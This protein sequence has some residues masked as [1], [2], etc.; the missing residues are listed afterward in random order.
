MA[1]RNIRFKVGFDLDNQ[2]ISQLKSEL[3]SLQQL[4]AKDIK[5]N[6]GEDA[7]EELRKIKESAAEI[8][9]ALNKAFNA[10]L[11]TLN[12]SK[13]NQE[14]K[15]VDTKQFAAGLERAGAAGVTSFNRLAGT[16]LSTNLQLKQTFSIVEKMRTTLSNTIKWQVASS[17]IN[18]MTSSVQQAFSY[19]KQLD[20]ALTDIRI[21]TG[22]SSDEMA[23]F[24]VQANRAAQ[25]LGKTTKDYAKA[26]LTYYQQGLGDDEVRARTE[27]TLKAANVT[28][29]A[30][31]EVAEDLTAVWN[32]YKITTEE[33]TL[34]VDKLAAVA[35]SSASD[36][37]ELATAMSKVASIANNMG[38]DIDQLN[39]QISTIIATTR[40][41]PET[42][43]NALK[44]IYA[45]INDIV[46]GTDEAETSLG[47]YSG[48][49]ASLGIS[50]LDSNGK[51]RDTGEVMEEIG[52]KWG[53]M[54]REQQVYLAKTMAGQR[55]MNNLIALF[56]N[57]S[58]YQ[59][60]INVSMSSVGALDEKNARY[61]ESVAAHAKTFSAAVEG[62]Q[63]ELVD[64]D[65]MKSLYDLGTDF[66][67]LITKIVDGIGGGKNA[68]LLMT[69][70]LT[71]LFQQKITGGLATIMGNSGRKEFNRQQRENQ[72]IASQRL[73]EIAEATENP[74]I[75]ANTKELTKLKDMAS[76]YGDV[77]TEENE[78]VLNG[79]IKNK[80]ELIETNTV[81]KEQL[82]LMQDIAKAQNIPYEGVENLFNEDGSLNIENFKEAKENV[83]TWISDSK[84]NSK[85]LQDSFKAFN[86]EETSTRAENIG[87][88]YSREQ[89][90]Y[91]KTFGSSDAKFGPKNSEN[92]AKWKEVL[93]EAGLDAKTS[94]AK[95]RDSLGDTAKDDYLEYQEYID[96][97]KS[98]SEQMSDIIESSTEEQ[99]QSLLELKNSF[100]EAY[101]SSNFEEAEKYA[102]KFQSDFSSQVEKV[103]E[104]SK[105]ADNVATDY[106]TNRNEQ[107]KL[108]LD[109]QGFVSDLDLKKKAQGFAQLGSSIA[110]AA[111]SAA[112]LGAS[113]S[114]IQ[115]MTSG[116]VGFGDGLIQ[117]TASLGTAVP[118][119]MSA[120]PAIGSAIAA[121]GPVL[122][123]IVAAG[124]AI[125]TIYLA[126]TKTSRDLEKAVKGNQEAVLGLS[127][128]FNEVKQASD[129][130]VS[131]FSEY[132][133]LKDKLDSCTKGTTEWYEALNDVNNKVLEIMTEYPELATMAGAISTDE[134]GLMSITAKGQEELTKLYEQRV[135]ATNAA[136]IQ[137]NQNLRN[138][139]IQ[140]T[141]YELHIN[142]DDDNLTERIKIAAETQDDN[143]EELLELQKAI[144]ENTAVTKAENQSRY[145]AA[146]GDEAEYAS[147]AEL[148]IGA[149]ISSALTSEIEESILQAADEHIYHISGSDNDTAQ[150]IFQR[151]AEAV[152]DAS[153][154]LKDVV[155]ANRDATLKILK[156]GQVEEISVRQAAAEIAAAEALDK[157]S[158]TAAKAAEALKGLE[159]VFDGNANLAG[160]IAEF[161]G[162]GDVSGATKAELEGLRKAVDEEGG[163][164]E[165]LKKAGFTEE[166]LA[167]ARKNLK[168]DD[169]DKYWN[170]QVKNMQEKFAE[171]VSSLPRN[172]QSY[173]SDFIAKGV[174]GADLDSISKLLSQ[175]FERGGSEGAELFSKYFNEAVN[176]DQMSA[177]VDLVTKTDF[178][179]VGV[180]DFAESAQRAGLTCLA[181]SEDARK[182]VLSMQTFSE[183]S[184]TLQNDFKNLTDIVNG[185][186]IGDIIDAEQYEKLGTYGQQYFTEMLDGTYKLVRSAK[187]LKEAVLEDTRSKAA[188][189]V[190][191]AL[192]IQV[193]NV[194]EANKWL[195]RSGALTFNSQAF[196]GNDYDV[197]YKEFQD[198][199]FKGLA[200]YLDK[201]L[202]TGTAIQE[203][204]NVNNKES[205][206]ELLGYV[207]T[208][209]STS[210]GEE[211]LKDYDGKIKELK[212]IVGGKD[213]Q[214]E[215]GGLK[216]LIDFQENN[217]GYSVL[218]N[219]IDKSL[220]FLLD[221][222]DNEVVSQAEKW[223]EAFGEGTLTGEQYKEMLAAVTKEEQRLTTVSE[224]F[225]EAL[226]IDLQVANSYDNIKDLKDAYGNTF[227]SLNSLNAALYNLNEI[228]D[229]QDLDTEE[230]SAYSDYIQEA[231][232]RSTLLDDGLASNAEAADEVAKSVLKLNIGIE[233]LSENWGDWKVILENSAIASEEYNEALDGTRKALANIF[234][235]SESSISADFIASKID[236]ISAAAEGSEEKLDEL[237]ESLNDD[238]VANIIIENG[239]TS[240][241]ILEDFNSIEEQLKDQDLNLEIGA[242]INDKE[243]IGNI[244][245]L[246]RESGMTVDQIQSLFDSLG[247]EPDIKLVEETM[248][249]SAPITTTVTKRLGGEEKA[250]LGIDSG[251]SAT[252]TYSYVTGYKPVESKV[253]VPMIGG[254]AGS[255]QIAKLTKKSGSSGLGSLSSLAGGSTKKT[256]SS[257]KSS[258]KDK[259]DPLEDTRDIYHDIN[260][261]ISD[262]ETSL[263]RIQTEQE[264]L[265]GKG[266]IK[267]LQEQVKLLDKQKDA[268]LRKAELQKQDLINQ[269]KVL[270]GLGATFDQYGNI[271]NYM[272]VLGE[273]QQFVNNLTNQYNN[274][275]DQYNNADETRRES[276][277]SQLETL[278][279]Q[280]DIAQKDYDL[281]EKK[282]GDYD[283]LM[284]DIQEVQDNIQELTNQQIELQIEAF[285]AEIKVSLDLSQAERDWNEF[286]KKVINRVADEDYLGLAAATAASFDSYY[287]TN[288]TGEVQELTEHL[289]KITDEVQKMTTGGHSSIYSAFNE[290]TGLWTNNY[291][292]A[293]EDLKEYL[294]KLMS[295]LE[296]ADAVITEV[297]NNIMSEIA[298]TQEAIDNQKKNYEQIDE[299]INHDIKM[300]QL[301]RG[302]D[303]YEEMA[304]YYEE[305]TRND[306]Q[307]VDLMKQAKDMWQ[308]QAAEAQA[309]RDR[310]EEGTADWERLNAEYEEYNNNYLQAMSDLNSAI[311]KAI[312]SASEQLKNAIQSATKAMNDSLFGGD[313]NRSQEEWENQKYHND[314]YIDDI[315]RATALL[316]LQRD[317]NEAITSA[318]TKKAQKELADY[319]DAE[320][321]ALKEKEHL[322][323]NDI[324]MANKRLEI[325]QKQMALEDAQNAKTNMRLVRDSQGNYTYQ[326]RADEDKVANAQEELEKSLTEYFNMAKDGYR[327]VVDEIY[328]VADEAAQKLAEVTA[329]YGESSLEYQ[330]VYEDFY[331]EHGKL[332]L[333]YEE[334]ANR[335]KDIED[336]SYQYLKML[337]NTEGEDFASFL[338][339]GG[340]IQNA[341]NELLGP[342]GDAKSILDDFVNNTAQKH[343]D[344]LSE[345]TKDALIGEDSILSTWNLT[346]NNIADN[347]EEKYETVVKKCFDDIF[348]ANDQWVD[349]I[350]LIEQTSGQTLEKIAEGTDLD[351]I[352]VQE[353]LKSNED[354]ISAYQT[355][356]KAINQV[357]Q[358]LEDLILKYGK[359]RD[360]A[361]QAATEAAK[362]WEDAN[363]KAASYQNPKSSGSTVTNF[364]GNSAS[365]LSSITSKIKAALSSTS[366]ST[367]GGN[368][369]KQTDEE[370]N[371][372]KT[373][374]LKDSLYAYLT[375]EAELYADSDGNISLR[376]VVP[377]SV[378]DA[379]RGRYVY[380]GRTKNYLPPFPVYDE[381]G[382]QFGYVKH[383]ETNKYSG[384]REAYEKGGYT[385]DW[386]GGYG[387]PA[388]LHSS[389][390]VL[391]AKDTPNVLR[392]VNIARGIMDKVGSINS[393]ML[394]NLA[395]TGILTT[396][397]NSNTN[398]TSQVIE[399]NASF[400]NA[401]NASEIEQALNNLVNS[402]SQRANKSRRIN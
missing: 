188:E 120:L 225:K 136:K 155:G 342:T 104:T 177:F 196:T 285:N 82:S 268:Y 213:Y 348:A 372:S 151:Y 265:T 200:E 346:I 277:E 322:T 310:F 28:G 110:T 176:D 52:S 5:I 197:A 328:S 212:G 246:I 284:D 11:G 84:K 133:D 378:L 30:V 161:L 289:T 55:Q 181:S 239:I 109:V 175:A 374:G 187:D 354:L 58:Q 182:F 237:R 315:N 41:A 60:M 195:T 108:D 2:A 59:E 375:K 365:A 26:A 269:Q 333:L 299:L 313:Y 215:L 254:D 146:L 248:T 323:Q 303:S 101:N 79:Y 241:S 152:G 252:Q 94:G 336:S 85:D 201:Q 66:F 15:K 62:F 283:S 329:I 73:T 122:I 27:A 87:K 270:A 387:K 376:N 357:G 364:V 230:W 280:L 317:I 352:A 216:G 38:V 83:K 394:D 236:L 222:A 257:S 39:A 226:S 397:Q 117:L 93:A 385:G 272:S 396:S 334:A 19:A 16:V 89:M 180:Q 145:V 198:S 125:A 202:G 49:M 139:K 131:S 311:E 287:K 353:L 42:V 81:L 157:V 113:V 173:M 389:E 335:A 305:K 292:K 107:E 232:K 206:E 29:A 319:R 274:L 300:L 363:N 273:K 54:T 398:T 48:Q 271:S 380:V 381:Q 350:G 100:E 18:A 242:E 247:Y 218:K 144:Q 204:F 80:T 295:T 203:G 275:I 318:S 223:S 296:N 185:L 69:A 130:L 21:V 338:G 312:E 316:D 72:K 135:T 393:S 1:D 325:Y 347:I 92:K 179:T 167:S 260:I 250:E 276:L 251:D 7:N 308:A 361:I 205:F 33:T 214:E 183:A 95:V 17:A 56:D 339:E 50:V 255:P 61:M 162:S 228:Q 119:L 279:E 360:A 8:E 68:V 392:A 53:N 57:W 262:Y 194:E 399:I 349:Q 293:Q 320:L 134:N 165:L 12:I 391:N 231:A 31:S 178:A 166:Q 138:S 9:G 259:K 224:E 261:E 298:E 70:A 47:N 227:Y 91:L 190:Q 147:E 220:E 307:Q 340:E 169:L 90:L 358:N 331:G 290:Q 137:A 373:S 132:N 76:T 366:G 356:L 258:K 314:R 160:T 221:S 383:L 309:R 96:K 401:N 150:D 326:Y 267:N 217:E 297:H 25:E 278:E 103:K 382:H 235:I 149:G 98:V 128:A 281:T 189:T 388:I 234:D 23:K 384:R 97:M 369:D 355:E 208:L 43:G 88:K 106:V 124:A 249:S 172:L 362:A 291:S 111:S 184:K 266:L 199:T 367:S 379:M 158:E 324:D 4:T 118:M 170:E 174:K 63:A 22:D 163:I 282:I 3:K 127:E 24:A 115:E 321:K 123:P 302:E 140:Q 286:R 368:V 288:S 141:A 75:I 229:S 99:K 77:M 238:I 78:E 126:A 359:A 13:F 327:E 400:P 6:I 45:R 210:N 345:Q 171:T 67:N 341:I 186:N 20:T 143:T 40:Q 343:W 116:E 129:N 14:L 301:L 154:Q 243:F 245:D 32:G 102:K 114:T 211:L 371:S 168:T 35:D 306:I 351:V 337:R 192:D 191:K 244:N 64:T 46:A 148:A 304:H 390:Y 36:L 10:N 370:T 402:A 332:P 37:S 377:S 44:T 207:Y 330:Q 253:Q 263:K 71:K 121:I 164:E 395:R 240:E 264:H 193:A 86:D 344:A 294:D 386:A 65:S 74:E 156:D 256:S 233:S 34:A 219:T 105:N 112:M 153:A 159:G 209:Q 51:L 142:L